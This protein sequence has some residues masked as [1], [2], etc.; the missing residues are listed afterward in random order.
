M[1]IAFKIILIVGILAY[2][3][4]AVIEFSGKP[5][6][7]V[8][9]GIDVEVL[10][11]D[12]QKILTKEHVLELLAKNKFTVVGEMRKDVNLVAMEEALLRDPYICQANC[13]FTAGNHLS[14][15]VLPLRPILH[16]IANNGEDYYVDTTGVAMPIRNFNLNVLVATGHIDARTIKKELLPLAWFLHEDEYWS[17]QTEQLHVQSNGDIILSPRVGNHHILLG[18]QE[19]FVEKLDNMKLFYEKGFPQV[20]WNK[21][22]TID[23][24][25]K[26]Q[27]I[28][29]K[30][31]K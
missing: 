8:C 30:H 17:H 5:E 7:E 13:Y 26:G 20:G 24:R 2:M 18:K 21:Y 3:V 27:V 28:G 19:D 25:Y 12:M 6:D 1:K 29:V 10:D 16:V 15:K 11:A 23:L 14:V 31:T 9:Q 22:H 4:F